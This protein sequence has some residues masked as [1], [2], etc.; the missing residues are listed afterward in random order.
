MTVG[1]L[2]VRLLPDLFCYFEKARNCHANARDLATK[3]DSISS[4]FSSSRRP[5][6][7]N[8]FFLFLRI[9]TAKLLFIQV[10]I[11]NA[12][13]VTR[14]R[15]WPLMIDPQDQAN[16]WIRQKEAKNNLKVI[17]LT[18][19]N[20]LRTL[21]NC[22]RI[23]MPVLLEEVGESLDPSLEPILLKQTFISGGRMLIRLG[24]NDI[25]YDKNFRFASS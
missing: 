15:R 17:K 13:L 24:D 12:V 4:L 7:Q 1:N 23:G 6:K 8:Q 14:G 2:S 3:E 22:I 19:P 18:N 5:L 20:F 25:D 10:S 9:L 11:E 21:E 16:R